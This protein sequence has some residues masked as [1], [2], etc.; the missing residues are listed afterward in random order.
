MAG[1]DPGI[2][3]AYGPV[4]AQGGDV[5]AYLVLTDDD[6]KPVSWWSRQVEVRLPQKLNLSLLGAP[7]T[8]TFKLEKLPGGGG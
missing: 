2:G 6:K 3:D 4:P 8:V 7:P 5:Q 1:H